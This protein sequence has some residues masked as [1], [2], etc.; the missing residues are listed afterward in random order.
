MID[1]PLLTWE[2]K[3]E[4]QVG[5]KDDEEFSFGQILFGEAF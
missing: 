3:L 2:E 5:S 4:V 1:L